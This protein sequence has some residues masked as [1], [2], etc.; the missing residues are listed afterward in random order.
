MSRYV[1]FAALGMLAVFALASDV[2]A[3]TCTSPTMTGPATVNTTNAIALSWSAP[4]CTGFES[5]T[6]SGY[7]VWAKTPTG[8]FAAVGDTA[9]ST[10]NFNYSGS[11][12]TTP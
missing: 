5:S 12:T 11:N 9:P 3:Q 8:S 2:A 7:R 1:R 10:R 6:F 4:S